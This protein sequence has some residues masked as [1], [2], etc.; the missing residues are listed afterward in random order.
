MV[1]LIGGDDLKVDFNGK[2]LVMGI[3]N[4]TPDSFSDGGKYDFLENAVERARVM[5]EEGADIIDIGGESTRPGHKQVSVREEIARVVPAIKAIKKALNI[6]LSIDTY[7]SQVAEAAIAAGADIINDV[8]GAKYDPTIAA[9]AARHQVP[10][11]LMHN[12]NNTSYT[13]LW[14]EVKSDIE[15]SIQIALGAGVKKEQIWLDPGI[16][17]GKNTRQ[18]IDMM[19]LLDRFSELGYPV[20]LGA[21]QKSMIGKILDVPVNE[22]LEGSL[23]AAC[24]GASKGCSVVRVHDVKETVQ[25]L[26]MT[27]VF[28]GKVKYQEVE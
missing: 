2:T 3:L 16:G 8:W 14:N 13:N 17:F 15:E 6:A 21:S 28:N 4:V 20:L 22:R 11:I 12:R 26:K 25:A 9:V 19:Q 27:D 7:K 24:Y 5:A 10:I 18:N 1:I 23:A